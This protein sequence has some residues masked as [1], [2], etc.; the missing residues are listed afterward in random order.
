MIEKIGFIV[1]GRYKGVSGEDNVQCTVILS[2]G[3]A[4]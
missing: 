4:A 2:L 1:E 3:I